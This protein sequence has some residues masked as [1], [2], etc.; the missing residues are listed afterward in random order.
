M[1]WSKEHTRWA[2]SGTTIVIGLL[3]AAIERDSS[4]IIAGVAVSLVGFLLGCIFKL[5]DVVA[6]LNANIHITGEHIRTC[7]KDA[8]SH[9]NERVYGNDLH[10]KF[11]H[12]RDSLAAIINPEQT[13]VTYVLHYWLL[14]KARRIEREGFY[15]EYFYNQLE[16]DEKVRK[17]IITLILNNAERFVYTC[18]YANREHLESFWDKSPT[19]DAYIKAHGAALERQRTEVGFELKRVFIV[20][21]GLPK[22]NAGRL[23]QVI[24]EFLDQGMKDNYWLSEAD[25]STL[26]T[27]RRDLRLP[28]RSFF[29]ADGAF[30]SE[31]KASSQLEDGINKVPPHVTFTNNQE[32]LREVKEQFTLLMRGA[33][34]NRLSNTDEI[35]RLAMFLDQGNKR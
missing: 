15:R 2:I 16:E 3:L 29:L 25:A 23:I 9:F 28:T 21:D 24:K 20:P 18:T 31:G 34:E 7:V 13:G 17:E 27:S 10:P 12:F 6:E 14:S 26:F 19:I 22:N 1:G 4:G 32:H 35:G 30:L 5:N 8:E 11:L 33:R